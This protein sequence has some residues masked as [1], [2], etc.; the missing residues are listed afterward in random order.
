MSMKITVSYD[1]GE[2]ELVP[3]PDIKV[4]AN[5]ETTLG[6][7]FFIPE[8]REVIAGGLRPILRHLRMSERIID[9]EID[10]LMMSGHL[11]DNLK[12]PYYYDVRNKD[13]RRRDDKEIRYSI[14]DYL[15]GKV[16]DLSV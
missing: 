16:P 8:I 9:K 10:A 15:E 4:T 7:S 13:I 14:R 5:I 2:D 12:Y 3:S 6:N 11:F 1:L